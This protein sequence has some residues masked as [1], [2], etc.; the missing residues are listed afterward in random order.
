MGERYSEKQIGNMIYIIK[1][2]R[3][4]YKKHLNQIRKRYLN[5]AENNPREEDPMDVVFNMFEVL[6]PQTASDPKENEKFEII[7]KKEKY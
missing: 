5:T 1:G 3:F 7:P 2:P 6:I 4:I